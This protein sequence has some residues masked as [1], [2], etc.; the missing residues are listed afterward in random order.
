MQ[1]SKE[2]STLI[3]QL[4]RTFFQCSS[5]CRFEAMDSAASG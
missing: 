3:K 1:A 2:L 5:S 4:S